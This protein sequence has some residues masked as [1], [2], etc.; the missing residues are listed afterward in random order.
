ML[1]SIKWDPYTPK[2]ISD[3]VGNTELWNSLYAQISENKSNNLILVGPPGSGKSL[4]LR[5]CL[6]NF[7]TQ[8]ID[9]TANFGLRDVRDS[10]RH[11]ARGGRINDN[12]RWLIFE[13]ADALTA[14]T[15]AYLRRMLETTYNT[16]RICFE[17]NDVGAITEPILSRC[18]LKYV[19]APNET[20][21]KYEIGRR[22]NFTLPSDII[23]IISIQSNGNLRYALQKAFLFKYT[24][25]SSIRSDYTKY[26][27]LC[28]KREKM[29]ILDWAIE[30]ESTCRN[31][32]LDFRTLLLLVWPN[33][34]TVSQTISQWSRLGGIS[35]RALFF[36]C[37]YQI[38]VK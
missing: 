25:D 32:G 8:Y 34:P 35:A 20:E 13:H 30:A 18:N 23:N 5:I 15:Q 9:C 3:I 36:N 27:D 12:L 21:V 11:F 2:H 4:F 6:E 17:C 33:N 16:T 7:H 10:I 38:C 14:D 26:M 19:Y 24:E 31:N 22:T 29:D 28:N 37:V 1:D